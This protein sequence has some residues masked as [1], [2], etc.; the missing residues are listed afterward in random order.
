[1]TTLFKKEPF[2]WTPVTF[3]AFSNLKQAVTQASSLALPYFSQVFVL[4]T[5]VSSL[6]IEAI[7]SQAKHWIAYFSKKLNLRMQLKSTY[8]RDI[9][10]ISEAMAN[11][12]QCILGHKFII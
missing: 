3:E 9:F 6:G 11:F 4:E 8:V 12:R 1:M 2:I 7:L 5:D 10:A